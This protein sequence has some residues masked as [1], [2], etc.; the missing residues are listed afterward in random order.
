MDKKAER[1]WKDHQLWQFIKFDIGHNDKTN[2]YD[3]D[4]IN[5]IGV[6]EHNKWKFFVSDDD[7]IRYVAPTGENGYFIDC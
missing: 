7:C 2:E 1:Y 5:I 6:V 3:E 4:D